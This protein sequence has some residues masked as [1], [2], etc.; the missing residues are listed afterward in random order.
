MARERHYTFTVDYATHLSVVVKRI[1][2]SARNPNIHAANFPPL[3]CGRK[4]LKGQIIEIPEF[5]DPDFPMVAFRERRMRAAEVR[6]TISFMGDFPDAVA[7]VKLVALGVLWHDTNDRRG[8]PVI[9]CGERDRRIELLWLGGW[10][11]KRYRALG[12]LFP[13]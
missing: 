6:E 5:A 12:I 10:W 4:R 13:D 1:G 11:G 2:F 3:D 8:A 9:H 7:D